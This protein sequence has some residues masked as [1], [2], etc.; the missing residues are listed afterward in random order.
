MAEI[1]AGEEAGTV[2]IMLVKRGRITFDLD[3]EVEWPKKKIRDKK[4]M[5]QRV[6]KK[7]TLYRTYQSVCLGWKPDVLSPS[8][9]RLPRP[10]KHSHLCAPRGP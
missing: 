8:G 3:G 7:G 2:V 10:T 1:L 5:A 4:T 6:K 9:F